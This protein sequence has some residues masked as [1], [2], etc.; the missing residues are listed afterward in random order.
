MENS[1]SK[2]KLYCC[3]MAT[4]F[5]GFSMGGFPG[6]A[7][8]APAVVQSDDFVV[9]GKSTFD[10][11]ARSMTDPSVPAYVPTNSTPGGIPSAPSAN[12]AHSIGKQPYLFSLHFKP[13][14]DAGKYL[15][16]RGIYFTGWNVSQ[17]S[18]VPAGGIDHG[19]FF[20]NF[21]GVGVDL[22]MQRLAHIPGA[23]IHFLA[24][25][26]AG[27]GRAGGNTGSS[28]GFVSYYGNHNGF[29]VR[30]FTWDQ[31]LFNNHLFIL[32]GR[33]MPKGGEFDGSELYCMFPS[34]LCS[35][36][37]TLTINGSM[38]SFVTSS[39]GA[40][41]LYKPTAKTY[42]KTGIWEA[43][44]SL[45]LSNHNSWPGPD[46]GFDRA[47]GEYIPTEVGYRT[48]FTN[49][50][51]PR[52]Y[53]LG[54]VYDTATYSDPLY[55]TMG[56]SRPLSGG[57]AMTRR[58]RTQ[59]Y[60]QA[61]QMIWKPEENGTRGLIVFAAANLM[62]SGD[63]SVKDGFVAGLFDWG[64][65]ASRPRDYVGFVS[66]TLIWDRRFVHG[67][68]DTMAAHGHNNQW[69]AQETMMELNYGLNI[70]PG[71]MFTPYVEYIWNP[72]Q[73]GRKTI[74]PNVNTAIQTGISLNVQ[75]SPAFGIPTLQRVRN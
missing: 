9:H 27:Q 44:P 10:P 29:Q 14:V 2:K 42:I 68:N 47:E 45:K 19:S 25:E 60:L 41:F 49:D 7:L 59:L 62:T 54:F 18:G 16:D 24:D 48:N 12:S 67:M 75:F 23:K 11:R 3:V 5:S 69:A 74:I 6:S 52:A 66:Q 4:I 13:I 15:G 58:G 65:F 50:K 51:Y 70:A 22:D 37:T 63:A 43:E 56:Q 61:Q 53:D 1:R 73:L 57:T 38:P 17:Y 26:V 40:R 20:N 71:V 33:S 30:E 28:W 34:F 35:V 39:W 21:A 36:P 64:P 8:A 72:D 32:A 31:A 55:N 46:W